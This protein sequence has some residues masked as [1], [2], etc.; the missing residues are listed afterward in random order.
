[1]KKFGSIV[2]IALIAC[3]GLFANGNQESSRADADVIR[4]GW[5]G[6]LSGAAAEVGVNGVNA[7]KVAIDQIN[8]NGGIKGKKLDLVSYDDEGNYETSVKVVTRLV[9]Q[10]KVDGIVG[11]HLSSSVLAACDITEKAKTPMFG[12]G[13]STI[14]TNIGLKYTWRGT[15]CSSLFNEGTYDAMCK[16]GATKVA[17][18]C[19]DTEY[20][21]TCTKQLESFVDGNPSMNVVATESWTTGDTNY[22][23]QLIKIVSKNPDALYIV[24]GGEDVG[25]VIAQARQQ[26]YDGYIY[27]VEPFAD[28]NAM[29]MAGAAF[30][31]CI[32]G[33]AYFIPS[34]IDLAQNDLEKSFLTAYKAKFGELPTAEVAYRAYDAMCLLANAMEHATVL[35]GDSIRAA[36][37]STSYTGI[38]GTFDFSA[39]TGEGLSQSHVY[40]YTDNRHQDFS[41]WRESK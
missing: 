9:E 29:K 12:T 2:C 39:D 18:I 31:N 25:K 28:T 34:S 41:K 7:V 26:G 19:G 32:F 21:Q 3:L 22:S 27:G 37:L 30:E 10:D 33:C 11:S 1:M 36:V 24:G 40:I 13:T 23:G 8:N 35:D 4:I 15:A 38:G 5:F 6:P 20:A 14:W 16:M 17:T